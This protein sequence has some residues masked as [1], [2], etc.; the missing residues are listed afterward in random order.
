MSHNPYGPPPP[1]PSLTCA[2]C[3]EEI[4]GQSAGSIQIGPITLPL[5][6][7]CAEAGEDLYRIGRRVVQGW[8]WLQGRWP[9]KP[10]KSG[11]S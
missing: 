10:P 9:R 5:C 6:Q 8:G 2:S 11:S 7:R 3:K 4:Q 1:P